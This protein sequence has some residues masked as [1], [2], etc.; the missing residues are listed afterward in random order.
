MFFLSA[1]SGSGTD[2]EPIVPGEKPAG[3]ACRDGIE[4]AGDTC[5]GA[6]GEPEADNVRFAGGY[7][8]S[9]ECTP[10][11]Q[12]GCGPDE[13]CISGGDAL[14]AFCVKLCSKADGLDCERDDQVCLGL[15]AFGGC[16][17]REAVECHVQNRTGC[18][19][20]DI[21]MRIGFDDRS[22]GRCET[23]C[24]PMKPQCGEG[25]GCYFINTYSAA[26][27]NVAGKSDR[28]EQCLCDKCC[29]PGLACTPDSDED[30]GFHCK[31]VCEVATNSGCRSGE[32]CV[33]LKR[34]SPWGGCVAPGS[35]GT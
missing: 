27:C 12:Q 21:C 8:T 33:Q 5:L 18:D 11:S 30:A 3:S 24:D 32:T 29:D 19:P 17:S 20:A 22:L 13:Y 10:D 15:G 9:I 1:C 23:V 35:A 2:D 28:E 4:C 31:T 6:P 25:L 34:G 14:P 16:F 7:C 26:V